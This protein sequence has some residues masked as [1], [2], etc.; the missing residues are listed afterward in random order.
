LTSNFRVSDVFRSNNDPDLMLDTYEKLFCRRCYSY[1]CIEHGSNQ[2]RH[3]ERR[4][5]VHSLL[6]KD[7]G[8]YMDRLQAAMGAEEL[9][10]KLKQEMKLEK[11]KEKDKNKAAKSD[12]P[13]ASPEPNQEFNNP[14]GPDCFMHTQLFLQ[15]RDGAVEPDLS[16]L[17]V[18]HLSP[19]E[20]ALLLKL[21]MVCGKNLCKA[22]KM[23][24]GCTC[25]QAWVVA[26]EQGVYDCRLETNS[27][28]S[29][30]TGAVTSTRFERRK[31]KK[32]KRSV[33]AS[34][35]PKF[36]YRG[37]RNGTLTLLHM[38]WLF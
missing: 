11:D 31:A 20:N 17:A 16:V 35:G 3:R 18:D 21:A 8:K 15:L 5:P 29:D 1:D 27:S 26:Y 9:R 7:F 30:G 19:M 12:T 28:S 13:F 32:Q 23:I 6:Q 34:T 22:A 2:P 33:S 25:K 14:C 36:T 37:S 38:Y 24:K 10:N 4:L